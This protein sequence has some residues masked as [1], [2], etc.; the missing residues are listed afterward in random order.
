MTSPLRFVGA[1]IV[2]LLLSASLL[3]NAGLPEW[4]SYSAVFEREWQQLTRVGGD[5]IA[6]WDKLFSGMSAGERV[7][8]VMNT[9]L[10]LLLILPLRWLAKWFADRLARAL[11]ELHN[12]LVSGSIKHKGLRAV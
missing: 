8:V 4:Q 2:L 10:P 5:F 3:V 1:F 11:G 6:A 7:S 12:R 9:G